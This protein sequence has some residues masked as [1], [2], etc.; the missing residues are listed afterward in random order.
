MTLKE[1]YEK[2]RQKHS[3]P[4]YDKL[5][6]VF[7]IEAIEESSFV[8]RTVRRH[9]IEIIKVYL[10]ILEDI[11]HPNSTVSAFHECK[12][13]DDD[14]KSIYDLY[15][16]LMGKVRRSN[17]LDLK[18]DEKLDSAYISEF[19]KEWPDLRKDLLQVL[20]VLERC[21]SQEESGEKRVSYFG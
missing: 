6:A 5:N 10:E 8:L 18:L 1:Q 17:I 19:F 7:E 15:G 14:K 4:S 11:I 16:R 12:F 3:L 20:G 13:F 2:H 9:I 21:W